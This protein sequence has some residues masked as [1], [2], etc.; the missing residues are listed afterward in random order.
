MLPFVL[1]CAVG[2]VAVAMAAGRRDPR[3]AL[4]I[5]VVMTLESLLAVGAWKGAG[6]MWPVVALGQAAVVA[7]AAGGWAWSGAG[8]RWA[9]A[10]PAHVAVAGFVLALPW[11]LTGHGSLAWAPW[12]LASVGL[13]G[14]LRPRRETVTL[15]L[16]APAPESRG[17][18]PAMV[19]REAGMRGGA[20]L[21]VVQI[22]D[23]HLGPFMSEA[24][25]RGVCERAVAAEP[26][27]IVLTGDYTTFSTRDQVAM[28]TRALSPLKNHPRVFAVRGNHDL[29]A[30]GPLATALRANGI[31]LLIDEAV[32]VETPTGP[33]QL[34][35]LDFHWRARRE[36]I[37]RVFA[38]LA[39]VPDATRLVLLHDPGACKHI[40]AGEADLV[41]S[42]HT[43]GGHV[44]TVALGGTWTV[45]LLL[46]IPDHGGWAINGNRLYVHRGTGHYG[47]PL[48]LGV[49]AEESVLEI[50]GARPREARDRAPP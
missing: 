48:R 45:P 17:R 18:F 2:V 39:R 50:V 43:H 31:R 33:V 15:D 34:V 11:A 13:A 12:A 9:V 6:P 35:G 32:T 16:A 40:P 7:Y 10:V 44:G 42:G 37:A 22:T 41:L 5:A 8:A 24:R 23:P 3:F 38:T 21:R 25:L 29:E 27:L 30:P 26:D 19:R 4:P 49:P 28:L 47:F 20:G 1:A 36:R 14:S 46:G